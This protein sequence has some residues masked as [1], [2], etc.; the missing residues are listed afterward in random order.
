MNFAGNVT[1]SQKVDDV[2]Y[3]AGSITSTE[4]VTDSPINYFY[5]SIKDGSPALIRVLRS[6]TQEACNYAGAPIREV[7][8][9]SLMIY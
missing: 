3:F 2:V 7:V 1:C 8:A 5:F 4:N 6:D 9:G